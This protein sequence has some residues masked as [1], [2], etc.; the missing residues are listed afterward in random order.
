MIGFEILDLK[1]F[2]KKLL[3]SLKN[4]QFN[5]T[6]RSG[7]TWSRWDTSPDFSRGNGT[8]KEIGGTSEWLFRGKK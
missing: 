1:I 4:F 8:G 7:H 2:T 3:N 5:T 6:I